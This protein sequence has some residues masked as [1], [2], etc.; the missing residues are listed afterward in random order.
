MTK[1]EGLAW[2]PSPPLGVWRTMK[3]KEQLFQ[4]SKSLVRAHPRNTRVAPARFRL[5]AGRRGEPAAMTIVLADATKVE[6]DDAPL[7]EVRSSSFIFSFFL[8]LGLSAA[9]TAQ[10]KVS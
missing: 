8:H 5:I 3:P 9:A 2:D 6:V 1:N 10:K 7:S 4:D